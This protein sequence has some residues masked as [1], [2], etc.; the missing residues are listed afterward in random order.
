VQHLLSS[1][2]CMPKLMPHRRR[3]TC[4]AACKMQSRCAKLLVASTWQRTSSI[5][6]P[7]QCMQDTAS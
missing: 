6:T 2:A 3:Q 7:H 1:H 4:A 5:R